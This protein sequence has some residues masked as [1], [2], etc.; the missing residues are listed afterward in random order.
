MIKNEDDFNKILE[1]RLSKNEIDVL[2]DSLVE[3]DGAS[4][5]SIDLFKKIDR[6]AISCGY[7]NLSSQLRYAF[8]RFLTSAG[9]GL[10]DQ[11]NC[12]NDSIKN[13]VKKVFENSDGDISFSDVSEAILYGLCDDDEFMGYPSSEPICGMPRVL[14]VGPANFPIDDSDVVVRKRKLYPHACRTASFIEQHGVMVEVYDINLNGWS[15]LSKIIEENNYD[16]ICCTPANPVS[17][18]DIKMGIF[19]DERCPESILVIGGEGA[20]F[21]YEKILQELPA[22]VI[23]GYGSKFLLEII[24]RYRKRKQGER[25]DSYFFDMFS[26]IPN[27]SFLLDEKIFRTRTINSLTDKYFRIVSRLINF[28]GIPYEKYWDADLNKKPKFDFLMTEEE[29]LF[30]RDTVR[31]VTKSHCPRK[32]KFCAYS[33]FLKY[34][35][36][37]REQKVISLL[38]K[39]ILILI[40]KVIQVYPRFAKNGL[41]FFHDDDFIGED[42]DNLL[43][44]LK[45]SFLK[46]ANIVYFGFT[47]VDKVNKNILKKLYESGFRKI[48]F[49]IESFSNKLLKKMNKSYGTNNDSKFAKS[50]LKMTL[51]QGIQPVM[52]LILFYPYSNFNDLRITINESV[53]LCEIGVIPNIYPYAETRAGSELTKE[54]RNG[55][56]DVEGKHILPLNPKIRILAEQSLKKKKENILK[57]R[58]EYKWLHEIPP[59]LD[60]LVFFKTIHE[61]TAIPTTEIDAAIKNVVKKY[62]G[63]ITSNFLNEIKSSKFSK[64]ETL[65]EAILEFRKIVPVLNQLTKTNQTPMPCYVSSYSNILCLKGDNRNPQ[66]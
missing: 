23:R 43:C 2:V 26:N 39:D 40:K 65:E 7:K 49:G 37:C 60:A 34:S 64:K 29:K 35:V 46:N 16:V 31:I 62:R 25:T 33:N 14:F 56:L 47:R 58:A 3:K 55:K 57:F 10:L 19:F 36:N 4:S 53:R 45:K 54:A 28:A 50:V 48:L 59:S 38:A 5:K 42:I 15:G 51:K 11:V 66:G 32:C 21:D 6:I 27:L 1:N 63:E 61:I 52:T 30:Y 13:E 17:E 8:Q 12:L 20:T 18:E 22:V 9:K 41:V 24:V 44:I